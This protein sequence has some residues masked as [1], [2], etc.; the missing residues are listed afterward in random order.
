MEVP[1]LLD[2]IS[3]SVKQ[4]AYWQAQLFRQLADYADACERAEF[5]EEEIAALLRWK[6]SFAFAQIMMACELSSKLP[7]TLEAMEKGDIDYYKAKVLHDQTLPLTDEQAA[8]VEERVLAKA[9]EQT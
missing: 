7:R 9:P 4:I 1:A 3:F 5:M 8:E 2:D 6:S